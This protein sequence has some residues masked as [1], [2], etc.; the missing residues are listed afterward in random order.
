MHI[1]AVT[2]LGFNQIISN[3]IYRRNNVRL[4]RLFQPKRSRKYPIQRDHDGHSLRSRCF[5]RFGQG[6]RPSAVAAE[7][8]ANESTVQRYFRDWK[9]IGL[10]FKKEYAFAK[11]LF[12]KTNRERNK[13]IE[14]FAGMLKI[15]KEELETILSQ[16]HGLRRLITG[17]LYFPVQAEN[18]HRQHLA[19]AVAILLTEHLTHGGQFEDVLLALRRYMHENRRYRQEDDSDIEDWNKN[20]PLIHKILETEIQKE[21]EVRVR[22]DTLS[23]EERRTVMSL[24]LA[25]IKK[26]MEML[27]WIRIIRLM[28]DGL[29]EEQARDKIVQ[30]LINKG[31]PQTANLMRELRNKVHPLKK[32]GP[33]SPEPRS[34]PPLSK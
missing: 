22:P 26:Q 18:D 25:E 11:E 20:M 12:K 30:D 19:L 15:K 27:Y 5:E 33:T 34:E 28:S 6:Q 2:L 8:K 29:T 10:D 13:N 16:P 24:E 14:L 21:Q 31:K 7:L 3:V 1:I 32:V 23:E 9:Q 17:K 4:P